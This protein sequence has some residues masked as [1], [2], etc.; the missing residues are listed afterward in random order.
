MRLIIRR[1]KNTQ[2]TTRP[3]IRVLRLSVWWTVESLRPWP[4]DYL[5][6]IVEW[7]MNSGVNKFKYSVENYSFLLL[8]SVIQLTV[9]KVLVQA[10]GKHA[11]IQVILGLLY[12][13]EHAPPAYR[14]CINA[15]TDVVPVL[16][17]LGNMYCPRPSRIAAFS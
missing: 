2:L 7:G 16:K 8:V 15:L 5:V 9:M 13:P 3:V 1:M 12:S 6:G 14:Y 4:T 11:W 17:F 10:R